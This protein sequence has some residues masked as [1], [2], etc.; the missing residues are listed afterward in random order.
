M[1]RSLAELCNGEKGMQKDKRNQRR[2]ELVRGYLA[3]GRPLGVISTFAPIGMLN[4]G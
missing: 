2:A 1:N 3:S 4:L